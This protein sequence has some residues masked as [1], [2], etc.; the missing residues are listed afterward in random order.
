MPVRHD[1]RFFARNFIPFFSFLL[2]FSACQEQ[3]ETT[4]EPADMVIRNAR[5]YTV[6]PQPSW[7]QAVAVKGDRIVWVGNEDSVSSHIG[8][9]T[10]VIDAGGKMMLPGFIDSHF[11]VLLGGNPD[12]LRIEKGNSLRE[13]QQQVRDFAAKRPDLKWIEVE[14]WNYSAFPHGTLPTAK[15]LQ[16]LTGGRP[17]FLV[18]YDYHTIW[19]NR[20]AMREFGITRKTEKVIFAEKVEKDASG[21]PTGIIT[22]FGSTGL[23]EDAETELRKHLPSHAPGQV[24]RGIQ[25]NMNQAVKAGITTI[26]DPQSYLEDLDIFQRLRDQGRLPARLQVALFHRR[27]TTEATLQKFDEARR[28]YNDDRLRIAAVKL[29]IDDVIEPHT[30][31]MLEPYADRPETRGELDYP[32]DEFKE[33]VARLDRMKFQVFVHSIGD[34]G[35]RTALDAIEYAEKQNGPRDRRDEL[36]HIEC[37]S[38]KDIPRF[39]QLGVIA[40]MQP[41]HCAPDI[42]GQWAKAVGPQRW[43]YAWAFRSLRDSG[44][45]LAFSSDWNVAEMEPLIGIYTALTRKGLDGKPEGGWVP[46]QTIDLETAIRAYTINGARANFVEQNRGS[47]TPGKYADLVIISD[48]LFKIPPDKIKD[49]RAVWTMVGGK[50]VWKE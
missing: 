17:A 2:V 31:A 39:K 19:L 27:G 13:I 46:E 49:A 20:E 29:Y 43:K 26:V 4:S 33:V 40:C 38:E 35:I 14:G 50:V 41:R 15:D 44:A 48:D 16:A 23:S 32:P 24:E 36:I 9:A 5:V 30:A 21:E 12:V 18:A 34:R 10:Q 3:K 28:K 37:L 42:T 1:A 6:D 45:T 7:A 8:P 22:G 25:W 11:H 47:I